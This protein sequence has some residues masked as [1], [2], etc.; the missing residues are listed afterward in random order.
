LKELVTEDSTLRTYRRAIG[1]GQNIKKDL[2]P[3]LT[4]LKDDARSSTKIIDAVIKIL[5][6]LTIPI[7]YLLPLEAM[8]RTEVGRHTIFEL[9][10][11]LTSSKEAFT[12]SRSTKV[13][14]DHIKF[15]VESDLEMNL[16]YCDSINN[17]LLLLRNILHVPE[18]KTIQNCP[19][20]YSTMQ[21][22]I[23]WNL[24]TQSVDK[25]IIYLISC[26]QKVRHNSQLCVSC[27][28]HFFR[29]IGA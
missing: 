5:V 16:E 22:Q 19:L 10:K 2:I 26:P 15:I 14:M 12:D 1:F 24:F 20:A 27:R 3:L 7:E 25:V 4:H 6:N 18:A 11:L 17:C 23:I 9:N 28:Q 29:C 21:N 13:I 8:S